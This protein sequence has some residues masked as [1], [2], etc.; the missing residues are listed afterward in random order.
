MAPEWL[1]H[2][3][4]ANPYA[5]SSNQFYWAARKEE[6]GVCDQKVERGRWGSI[7]GNMVMQDARTEAV[8]TTACR[9]DISIFRDVFLVFFF[10]LRTAS[11][12]AKPQM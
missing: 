3:V 8:S 1:H 10:S 2:V 4:A 6:R 11:L 5:V 7:M 9:G 12:A